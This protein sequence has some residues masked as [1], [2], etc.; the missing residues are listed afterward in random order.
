MSEQ[1]G[2]SDESGGLTDAEAQAEYDAD[3]ELQEMLRQAMTSPRTT[4][5]DIRRE[6]PVDAE[7]HEAFTASLLESIEAYKSRGRAKRL[8]SNVGWWVIGAY[9]R[10][11]VR[12]R[13]QSLPVISWWAIDQYDNFSLRRL[14]EDIAW[15][16]DPEGWDE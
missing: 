12:R 6:R 4:M 7:D 3:P 2:D 8:I 11:F 14:I 1:T 13:L 9:D 15:W 5:D 16:A 10:S